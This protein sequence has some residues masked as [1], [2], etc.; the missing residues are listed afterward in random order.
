MNKTKY[1]T[2]LN[3][4]NWNTKADVPAIKR[5]LMEKYSP[6][7]MEEF[8]T[9]FGENLVRLQRAISEYESEKG[10][11]NIGS[12]DGFHDVTC[13]VVGLGDEALNAAIENPKLVEERYND[14]DY[15]EN[16]YYAIPYRDDYKMLT[17][18]YYKEKMAEIREDLGKIDTMDKSDVLDIVEEIEA[19]IFKDEYTYDGLAKLSMAAGLSPYFLGN[20]WSDGRNYYRN[21]NNVKS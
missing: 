7:E 3:E 8:T 9:A 16:V 20:I 19:G 18:D 14:H 5:F 1:D 15:K 12:D 13:H 21:K 11:I 4:I 6:E 17:L 10:D 2:I